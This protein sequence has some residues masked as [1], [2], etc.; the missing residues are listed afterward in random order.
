MH[1][2]RLMH[3]LVVLTVALLLGACSAPPQPAPQELHATVQPGGV[4]RFTPAPVVGTPE[5]NPTLTLKI[6]ILD[7]ATGRPVRGD[8]LVGGSI[9]R[10][11]VDHVE[12]TL[13]GRA[14]GITVTVQTPG[15][16][17]W[18]Q[19]LSYKLDHSRLLSL[20]AELTPAPTLPTSPVGQPV[21]SEVEGGRGGGSQPP[22]DTPDSVLVLPTSASVPVASPP[23]ATALP[24]AALPPPVSPIL[25]TPPTP[26][27]SSTPTPV[28]S[29]TLSPPKGTVEGPSDPSAWWSWPCNV[30]CP[31]YPDGCPEFARW[32]RPP[33][34]PITPPC[35]RLA[36]TRLVA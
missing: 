17:P 20:R 33:D 35:I 6:A 12:I 1:N 2:T 16:A 4:Y 28:L 8:V 31:H 13:P 10:R 21:L 26:T 19:T 5:P 11:G 23:T 27:P 7:A 9:L 3:I 24:T 32:D 34:S 25:P 36:Y 18:S 15:Y 14:T 30:C 29:A 22:T